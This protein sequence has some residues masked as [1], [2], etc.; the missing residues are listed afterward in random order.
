MARISDEDIQAV[1]EATDIVALVSERVQLKPRSRTQWGC[2]PF[3]SERTPSFKVDPDLQTWHCFGCGKGGDVFGFL[4]E[5]EGMDFPDA[6]R[7]LAERAHVELSEQDG[8]RR[9]PQGY[10]ERLK[11]IMRS[12]EDFYH[13]ALMRNRTDKAAGAR[14]YLSNRGF[15]AEVCRR[16]NLGFAP[17]KGAL[18]RHLSKD[19]FVR[20]EL[21]AS[22]MCLAADG[23]VV[24]DRFFERIMFPI[25]DKDGNAIA[26]GGRVIGPT[27]PHTGKY[28]NT[29]DTPVFKKKYNLFAIDRAKAS[30]T[31]TGTAVIVEGYTDVIALHEANITNVVATLG[32]ALTPEHLR[33][34]RRFRPR[35]IVYLFDG[36]D[37]GQ[38]AA[39]RAVEFI[40][41]SATLE[42]GS[43]YV[44][45]LVSIIP[46]GAD[47]AE[48]VAVAGKEG[49]EHVIASASPLI[50]FAIYRRLGE[51]DLVHASPEVRTHALNDIAVLL[52]PIK[53]T[54][55]AD[56]YA[57]Y[58]ADALLTSYDV[59]S[60]AFGKARPAPH[61][62][63]D[64]GRQDASV[65]RKLPDGF[66]NRGVGDVTP[67][68]K[69][70]GVPSDVGA[71][72]AADATSRFV[73]AKDSVGDAGTTLPTPSVDSEAQQTE[74]EL[75]SLVATRPSS[76]Q[77]LD[78]AFAR[79]PWTSEEVS[80][81]ARA[82]LAEP[83]GVTPAA[84]VADLEAAIPGSASYLSA[85]AIDPEQL[86]GVNATIA[87]FLR[88]LREIDLEKR[89]RYANSTLKRAALTGGEA[90]DE[91][92]KSVAE[93]QRELSELRRPS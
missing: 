93:L 41:Y 35:R 85:G 37:A 82:M 92:F 61:P 40:D 8:G 2:C 13:F 21:L 30:I 51:A 59:V 22:N 68:P 73:A 15:N 24:R 87:T 18:T 12:S 69:E 6:V 70:A 44:E 91:L 1:R 84:L 26:F 83:E 75:L 81:R 79:T 71:V 63:A 78:D 67:G 53:G 90:Y 23:G 58:V 72:A 29:A 31:T 80:A 88:R 52:A 66:A 16:W 57:N 60:N 56:D 86:G 3:H 10:R 34:L 47:P 27:P 32:T 50:R 49:M 42:A 7:E 55:M 11:A 46:G 4:M 54:L 17:G 39:D 5:A 33:L 65:T 64:D 38:R 74:R 43:E 76:L 9:L 20:D 45:L 28:I 36:D 25:H 14:A 62:H 89:I 19:G 48:Y 77:R